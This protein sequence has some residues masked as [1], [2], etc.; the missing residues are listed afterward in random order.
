MFFYSHEN[1]E[2]PH[3]HCTKAEKSAKFF[4]ESAKKN[5]IMSYSYNMNS[6]DIK[7]V[8]DILYDNYDYILK[9]WE[10]FFK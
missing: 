8:E 1:D 10:E 7:Q 9:K 2:P 6:K 3:V 5:L 4:L